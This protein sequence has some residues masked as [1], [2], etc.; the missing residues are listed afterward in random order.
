MQFWG[1]ILEKSDLKMGQNL[2]PRGKEI[3]KC[4]KSIEVSHVLIEDRITRVMEFGRAV[5]GLF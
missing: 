1:P 3:F 2:D 4:H 5:L